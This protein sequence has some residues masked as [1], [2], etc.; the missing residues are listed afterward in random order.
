MALPLLP[1]LLSQGA[2]YGATQI[3]KK[4]LG[5]TGRKIVKQTGNI[6][7][8]YGNRAVTGAFY[9]DAVNEASKGNYE[10]LTD[11]AQFGLMGRMNRVGPILKADDYITADRDLLKNIYRKVS[12]PVKIG[13]DKLVRTK[14]SITKKVTKD[15]KGSSPVFDAGQNPNTKNFARENTEQ[16]YYSTKGKKLPLRTAVKKKGNVFVDKEGNIATYLPA[17]LAR[18]GSHRE[19]SG[20]GASK[21]K[22]YEL[23]EGRVKTPTERARPVF[24]DPKMNRAEAFTRKKQELKEAYKQLETKKFD[25]QLDKVDRTQAHLDYE[26]KQIRETFADRVKQVAAKGDKVNRLFYSSKDPGSIKSA[27][28]YLEEA[29]KIGLIVKPMT[30]PSKGA[31]DKVKIQNVVK[32]QQYGSAA[33]QNTKIDTKTGKI[34]MAESMKQTDIADRTGKKQ[35]LYTFMHAK[36]GGTST[37]KAFVLKTATGDR[38]YGIFKETASVKRNIDQMQELKERAARNMA[39]ANK[40]YRVAPKPEVIEKKI[41]AAPRRDDTNLTKIGPQKQRKFGKMEQYDIIFVDGKPQLR[42]PAAGPKA[43][44]Q[45]AMSKYGKMTIAEQKQQVDALRKLQI[46]IKQGTLFGGDGSKNPSRQLDLL[47]DKPKKPKK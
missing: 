32:N 6:A 24:T 42:N 25:T 30:K 27:K 11:L 15:E 12:K 9:V 17:D 22:G 40:G 39:K 41:Y 29:K 38:P 3:G 14:T 10:P 13:P 36:R 16:F 21:I 1:L 7:S 33:M 4:V 2:R 44:T 34:T 5:R 37:G 47:K 45:R 31:V 23:I 19:D 8:K 18:R 46:K 43:P 35:M 26:T 20:S 28:I